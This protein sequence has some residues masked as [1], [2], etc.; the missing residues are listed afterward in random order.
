MT[1]VEHVAGPTVTERWERFWFAPIST[2]TLEVFRA[3]YG[4]VLF[5]WTLALAPN[6]LTFFGRDGILPNHPPTGTRWSLLSWFGSDVAVVAV[7]ALL[8]CAAVCIVVGFRTRPAAV[9]A[10]VGLIALTRRNPFMFNSG[11]ALLRNI[12]LFMTV[13]PAGVSLSRDAY[14]RGRDA[15]WRF[16]SRAPWALRLVQVQISMVYLFTVWAKARGDRWIAGTAVGESLRVGDIARFHLPYGLSNSLLLVNLLTFGTLVVELSLAILIWNRRLRPWVIGA[17]IA[18]HL[19]IELVFALGF[20]SIVMITS[21]IAFVPEDA[22]ERWLAG[23]R[24]RA[25]R[26]RFG[27]VRRLAEGAD[28]SPSPAPAN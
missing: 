14:K 2:A 26:S 9:V 24:A 5:F 17:G 4:V 11:D 25:R 20:F 23:V 28:T 6:A 10:F 15:F 19:F 21:Y 1:T 13:A 16:A 22:M 7:V 8:L 27:I 3:A 18:L 12:A